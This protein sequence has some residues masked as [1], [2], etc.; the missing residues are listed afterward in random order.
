M[1]RHTEYEKICGTDFCTY[2]HTAT[3]RTALAEHIDQYEK[4]YNTYISGTE[5]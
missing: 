1:N 3:Y 4:M 2:R 5:N